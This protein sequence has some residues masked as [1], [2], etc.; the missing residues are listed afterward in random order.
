MLRLK[1][2]QKNWV[3]KM[4]GIALDYK[5]AAEG[6]MEAARQRPFRATFYAGSTIFGLV[7]F[8]TTPSYSS[9]IANLVESSNELLLCGSERSKSA[10]DYVQAVMQRWAKGML[11]YADLK[12]FSVV[13]YADHNF[14]TKSFKATCKYSNPRWRDMI[15]YVI[16][17]GF[18]GRWWTLSFRMIDYDVDFNE[19]PKEHRNVFDKYY[20][21]WRT[22]IGYSYFNDLKAHTR[23]TKLYVETLVSDNA[24][25]NE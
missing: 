24:S 22:L 11:R 6:T 18:L 14:E 5:S 9:Y 20:D 25:L 21:S 10:D 17:V 7:A 23:S 16:D 19:I 3:A 8:K 4:K 13:Y 1:S 15:D 2:F 12:L